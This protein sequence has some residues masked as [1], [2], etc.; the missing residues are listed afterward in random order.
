MKKI[1]LTKGKVAIVDDEDYK[2]LSRFNWTLVYS[3]NRQMVARKFFSGRK[4]NCVPMWRFILQGKV[5]ATIMYKNKNPLDCRKENIAF[6]SVS[7][8]RHS[9]KGKKKKDTKYKGVYYAKNYHGKNK[10]LAR[11]TKEGKTYMKRCAT[12]K[13]AVLFYNQKAREIYGDFAYQNSFS[14]SKR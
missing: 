2:Y 9:A 14:N 6:V 4:V 10:W 13:D 1:S 7:V 12:E 3:E 8:S 5:G 11:V